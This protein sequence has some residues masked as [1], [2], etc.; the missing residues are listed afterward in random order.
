MGRLGDREE[1]NAGP[2]RG[3]TC[4]RDLQSFL[5]F[6]SVFTVVWSILD[7][8]TSQ[9]KHIEEGAVDVLEYFVQSMF[10]SPKPEKGGL[11][12]PMCNVRGD[13]DWIYIVGC[14]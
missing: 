13:R 14:S 2:Q 9:G 6:P 7:M 1:I 5:F 3:S 12:L 4:V 11:A 8:S 10:L